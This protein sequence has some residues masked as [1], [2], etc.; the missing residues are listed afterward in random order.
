MS[1]T[2][3]L[4]CEVSIE[5]WLSL[6]H[7]PNAAWLSASAPELLE[8]IEEEMDRAWQFIV[9]REIEAPERFKMVQSYRCTRPAA[10][11]HDGLPGPS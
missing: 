11:L 2:M 9:D 8:E 4:A 5:Y 1:Y 10:C 3:T 6:R 7:S